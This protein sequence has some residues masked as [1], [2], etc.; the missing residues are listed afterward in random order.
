M[1]HDICNVE[2]NFEVLDRCLH[3]T[4]GNEL[5]TTAHI[6]Q[7]KPMRVR[8]PCVHDVINAKVLSLYI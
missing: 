2:S 7:K 3:S 5:S 6:S 4:L 8:H 1:R